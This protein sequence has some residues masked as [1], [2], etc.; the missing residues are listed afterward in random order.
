LVIFTQG[1]PATLSPVSWNENALCTGYAL[2]LS[3]RDTGLLDS[4]R[5]NKIQRMEGNSK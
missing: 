1:T 3:L 4:K 5:A 2:Q